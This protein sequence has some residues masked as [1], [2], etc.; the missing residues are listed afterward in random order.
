MSFH[1]SKIRV[2]EKDRKSSCCSII[3]HSRLKI[4]KYTGE[5]AV[6]IMSGDEKD[7]KNSDKKKES[8]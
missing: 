5:F 2:V 1:Y 3:F 8:Q 7:D 4:I 6:C